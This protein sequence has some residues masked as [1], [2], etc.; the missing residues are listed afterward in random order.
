[1]PT[2]AFFNVYYVACAEGNLSDSFVLTMQYGSAG[3]AGT[4]LEDSAEPWAGTCCRLGTAHLAIALVAVLCVAGSVSLWPAIRAGGQPLEI[5][6]PAHWVAWAAM[7]Y[8]AITALAELRASWRL[9]HGHPS[10]GSTTALR[11]GIHL[12]VLGATAVAIARGYHSLALLAGLYVILPA[13]GTVS[14]I[15][16]IVVLIERRTLHRV[17]PGG[18]RSAR[19]TVSAPAPAWLVAQWATALLFVGMLVYLEEQPEPHEQHASV[20]SRRNER[21][22]NE[23]FARK[24]AENRWGLSQF[25]EGLRAK[26]CPLLR[27]GSRIGSHSLPC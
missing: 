21:A 8:L 7:L 9:N 3:P 1:M 4:S 27:G 26:Y 14:L 12:L 6:A 5:D 13:L 23:S 11:L 10:A 22:E 18:L 17:A 24:T 15:S 2:T 25:C 20:A 19:R 16:L